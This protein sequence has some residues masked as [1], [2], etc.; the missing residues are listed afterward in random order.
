M[1]FLIQVGLVVAFLFLGFVF[2][3]IAEKR[4]YKSIIKREKTY[5][6][7]MMFGAKFPDSDISARDASLVTGSAVVSIDYFK[8]FVTGL[9]AIVGGRVRSYETLVDRARREAILRMKQQADDLGCNMVFNIKIETASISKGA[10]KAI[11]SVEVLAYGTAVA[12][13]ETPS[14]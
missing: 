1:E 2:G 9:R 14:T 12:G 13:S 7:V 6:R 11:G 8:R 4:H 3:Q 5:G 10:G